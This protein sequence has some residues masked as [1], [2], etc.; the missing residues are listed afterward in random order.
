MPGR[1][2]DAD[3]A[4]KSRAWLDELAIWT[5]YDHPTDYPHNY[6]ARKFFGETPTSEIMVCPDV[7]E[8]RNVLRAYGLVRLSRQD[9]DDPK[10]METW[11]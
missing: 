9:G 5:V 6:V 3:N 7:D 10:I 4:R 8:I 1:D 11:L 2:D